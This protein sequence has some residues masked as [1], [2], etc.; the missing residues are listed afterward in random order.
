VNTGLAHDMSIR[1]GGSL[2][3]MIPFDGRG[4]DSDKRGGINFLGQN[5]DAV[6]I[7]FEDCWLD[8]GTG[9]AIQNT[10]GQFT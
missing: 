6:D 2:N 7:L 5:E 10:S 1:T 8:A 4:S 9:I 3:G